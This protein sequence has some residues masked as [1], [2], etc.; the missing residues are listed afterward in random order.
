MSATII[1]LAVVIIVALSALSCWCG[2]LA[3]QWADRAKHSLETSERAVKLSRETCIANAELAK[4]NLDLLMKLQDQSLPANPI[5]PEWTQPDVLALRKFLQNTETGAKLVAR[6]K[7]LVA[8][9]A[10][11][12]CKDVMHTTHSAAQAGGMNEMLNWLLSLASD[13]MHQK[14]SQPTGD[15][16]EKQTSEERTQSE[17]AFRELLSP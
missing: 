2:Y 1:I 3:H 6:G 11:R 12:A 16:V 15:Q 10:V 4:T 8:F 9:T 17:S 5:A 13:E 14:L 7:A